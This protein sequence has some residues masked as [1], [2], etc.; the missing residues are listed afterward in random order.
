MS[1][2][3]LLR[4]HAPISEHS[5]AELDDEAGEQ[6]RA[7]LG[8]RRLVDFSGPH[9]WPYSAIDLGRV[10]KVGSSDD[11]IRARRRLV[12]PVVELRTDFSIS[13][14]ELL[15]GDRGAA[16]LDLDPLDDAAWEMAVAENRA[17]FHGWAEAGITGITQ[18]SP[19][20]PIPRVDDFDDYP[21]SVARAVTTLRKSGVEG[22]YAIA[23]G[24][25]DYTSLLETTEDGYPIADHIRKILGGP[26]VWAPGV[27]GAVVLSTRGGDYEFHS[28]QDISVGFHHHDAE[29]VH[30][31][32][33]Q[34]FGF[35]TN[36]PDAGIAIAAS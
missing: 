29:S 2:N 9:G 11:T 26:I 3:H 33:E 7:N 19:H 27:E 24:P 34:S 21:S 31:Y 15:D 20:D 6:L 16:D 14:E 23:V 4:H 5:W 1:T 13:R 35:R 17:V 30:L 36:E 22:P 25:E 12:L 10:E 32:L 18:A 8:A 28:G